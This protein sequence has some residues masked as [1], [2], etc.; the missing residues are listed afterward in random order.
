M[1]PTGL[2]KSGPLTISILIGNSVAVTNPLYTGAA[3]GT[4]SDLLLVG[5]IL[6]A[7]GVITLD[8][9][10]T[11]NSG[12]SGTLSNQATATALGLPLAGVKTDNAGVTADLPSTV[13]ASPFGLTI[14]TG[15]VT[16]TIA[17]TIDPVTVTVATAP[18]VAAFKSVKLTT[19][20]DSSGTITAGDTL[21]WT[22][23]YANTGTVD[24]PNFQIADQLPSGITIT[25]AGAQTVAFSGSG[26]TATKDNAYTGATL[27][28]S[29]A[30][31]SGATLAQQG[32]ITLTIPVTV[33]AGFTGT[34]S[35]QASGS[36]T[37][38][39][40]AVSTDNAGATADLPATVTATPF[41]LTV[42]ATSVTQTINPTIDPTLATVVATPT[43]AAYK[44]V[45]LTTDADSSGSVTPG[46]TL[47]Y[48]LQYAN[49]GTVDVTGFQL[50][51]VLPV[52]VTITGTGNQTLTITGSTSA[53]KNTNYTGALAGAVSE[54][55]AA[56]TTFK[57]G[58]ILK[59]EIPVT[60]N[61]GAS[62]TLLN[63][64]LGTGTN[65]P[66][67]GVKTDNV[68]NV[69]SG[70]PPGVTVPTGSLTQ[71]Q[72]PTLDPYPKVY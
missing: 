70:L 31:A 34:L 48:T 36:G 51:D 5:G 45:K 21:T 41:S 13:T 7:N 59:L 8:I 38:M 28:T 52:G 2:T 55:L 60:I 72:N 26:T 33:N 62:G 35:N 24:V 25:A 9:P 49:T 69:T 40:T 37:G 42:P 1:L 65:L 67:P 17:A 63:Q 43:V 71:T 66:A 56:T 64:A 27:A 53:A 50:K 4:V 18:T 14:P 39:P 20:T 54:L 29:M 44:S 3:A 15:S 61:A 57:A 23:Q 10:V 6:K 12:F 19:D 22:V 46:D 58:D 68:D 47:T 30:L 11:V 32:T 16:Q